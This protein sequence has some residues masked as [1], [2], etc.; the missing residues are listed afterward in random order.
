MTKNK[1][2]IF[3]IILLAIFC[4][5]KTIKSQNNFQNLQYE[6]LKRYHFGFSLGIHTQDLII[7]N[8]GMVSSHGN[9]YYTSIP[10]YQPGFYVGVLGDLRLSNHFNLRI[11]PSLLFGNKIAKTESAYKN[12]PML[13]TEIRSNYL[14]LP[15]L[16]KYR[17]SRSSN[18]RP[19]FITGLSAGIDMSS[20]KEQAFLLKNVNYYYEIG[21]GYDF[22][23]PYFKL[24][25]ELKLCIGLNDIFEHK[26]TD[27][28]AE[29][30]QKYSESISSMHSRILILAFH[31]E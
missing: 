10:S 5:N 29:I 3:L 26:R 2:H 20:D 21:F 27:Q 23:L 15:L 30:Y 4:Q 1:I 22:Y 28:N 31:F 25:P 6:D 8:S 9:T 14:L 19:Y 17:G 13:R 16:I 12:E 7:N 18:Y 11:E 24:V